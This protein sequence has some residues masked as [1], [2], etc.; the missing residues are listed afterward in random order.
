MIQSLEWHVM[1]AEKSILCDNLKYLLAIW[2]ILSVLHTVFWPVLTSYANLQ[3]PKTS[4]V[5]SRLSIENDTFNH[6]NFENYINVT[7]CF[8]SKLTDNALK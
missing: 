7:Q 1:K 4:L 8:K 3:Y 5:V 2:W 6:I